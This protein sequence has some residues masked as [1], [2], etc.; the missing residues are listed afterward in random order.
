MTVRTGRPQLS[1]RRGFTLIELMIVVAVMVILM[2]SV[3]VL[4]FRATSAW[5]SE[6][7][8]VDRMQNFRFAAEK[9]TVELRAASKNP[10]PSPSP[11]AGSDV[12]VVPT[13]NQMSDCL[14]FR[15]YEGGITYRYEY[16]LEG[17]QTSGYRIM[18][19]VYTEATP[20][21]LS[22]PGVPEPVTEQLTTLAAMYFVRDGN[23]IVMVMVARYDSGGTQQTVS[24]TR[25]V[26]LR[27]GTIGS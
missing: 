13:Q 9:L 25:Q 11:W 10:A 16:Y 6:R 14:S 17:D 18:R 3:L 24:Y 21:T 1:S 12:V 8:R 15:Y 5:G 26:F 23:R 22:N 20:G 27:G 2:S 7:Q 4:N 19:Q